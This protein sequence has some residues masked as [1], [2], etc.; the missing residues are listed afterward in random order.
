MVDKTHPKKHIEKY[1]RAR[2]KDPEEADNIMIKQ[3]ITSSHKI[4]EETEDKGLYGHKNFAPLDSICSNCERNWAP[5]LNSQ[6]HGNVK[7]V[8][9]LALI[10]DTIPQNNRKF[11]RH[12]LQGYS[13]KEKLTCQSCGNL[14]DE[15][16]DLRFHITSKYEDD[17]DKEGNKSPTFMVSIIT[18]IC[19]MI[20]IHKNKLG[21]SWAKLRHNWDL[22]L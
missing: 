5:T 20:E 13:D 17:E 18:M 15:E 21:P 9:L 2:M 8:E 1:H 11:K 14:F 16:K 3:R 7:H 4:T 12:M 19:R 6:H 10:C 22:M